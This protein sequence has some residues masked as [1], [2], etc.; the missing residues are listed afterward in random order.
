M[1]K[2][3]TSGIVG[4]DKAHADFSASG[5]YR[6]MACPGS[7]ELCKS[8]PETPESP[9]AAEGTMAHECVEFLLKNRAN[10]AAA[11]KMAKKKYPPEM[12]E[13]CVASAD[14]IL[15]WLSDACQEYGEDV[16]FLC[17]TKVDSSLFTCGGQF[18]TLDA[19]IVP[20]FGRLTVI[21]FKYGAGTVVDPA[22]LDG[23]GNPQL[24]YYA[25]ALSYQYDHNFTDVELVVIQ[26]RAFSGEDDGGLRS[27]VMTMAELK[28]WHPRFR[29][30]VM[31]TGPKSAPLV[32]GDHCRYCGAKAICPEVKE[33]A[34]EQAKIVF[35]DAE[36][37]ALPDP[38]LQAIPDLAQMLKA[39]DKLE[40]WIE[41]VRAHAT[42]VLERG[43][44]VPGFKLVEKRAPRRWVD[45]E[46]FAKQWGQD[47]FADPKVLS[48][49]QF[50]KKF[51]KKFPNRQAYVDNFT[52]T[53][54]SGNTMVSESD[55]RPAVKVMEDIFPDIPAALPPKRKTK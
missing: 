43:G 19:A 12:V 6:W 44:K 10:F 52:H 50:E 9:Y 55:K 1:A 22:G 40:T 17:E 54:S 16:E 32:A 29:D 48:P 21:D 7:I 18:G 23:K 34:M 42:L 47:A 28:A 31:A 24:V 36:V 25:L 2:P 8:A 26:P 20:H 38:K 13:H 4:G 39:A 46:M 41:G 45:E 11:I 15:S 30:A 37:V 53:T 33:K 35:A 27:H 5:A 51:G 49:A 3:S 14:V